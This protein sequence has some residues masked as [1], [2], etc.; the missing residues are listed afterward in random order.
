MATQD[1]LLTPTEVAQLLRV[2]PVTVRQWAQKGMLSAE[3]TPGGHR[4]FPLAVV[5]AFARKH[6]LR[7]VSD[8]HREIRILIVDDDAQFAH[9]LAESLAQFAEPVITEIALDG[10]SAGRIVQS[11]R[12][13]IVLLDLRMPGLD[14]VQVCKQ[15]KSDPAL[16]ATRVIAMTGYAHNEQVA[17]VLAAGAAQCL[18][19]PFKTAQLRDAMGLFPHTYAPQAQ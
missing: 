13:A 19:K 18:A 2:A 3:T 12:P 14:G 6:G 17:Q 16:A 15:I 7:F 4:R 11:F 10:F 1:R 5:E 9:Y 8:T